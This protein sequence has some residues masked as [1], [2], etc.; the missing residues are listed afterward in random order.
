M[1]LKH[2]IGVTG[3]N[4]SSEVRAGLEF[5]KEAGVNMESKHI[6]MMG[7]LMSKRTLYDI[8]P[9]RDIA[10]NQKYLNWR[11]LKDRMELSKDEALNAV[12][13][14]SKTP[15]NIFSDMQVLFLRLYGRSNLY[16][17]NTCRAVQLNFAWPPVSE[18]E[19][20]LHNF[21]D[22]TM[23]LQLPDKATS[24]LHPSKIARKLKEYE[25][26]IDYALIDPSGG[27]GKEFSVNRA[28]S[29]YTTIRDEMPRLLVGVAGGL[30]DAN[31]YDNISRFRDA[32]GTTSF[33]VDSES[34]LRIK[35]DYID[36]L[37]LMKV[38]NYVF[39]AAQALK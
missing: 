33:S 4:T 24:G 36:D 31:A 29:L 35:T 39:G 28:A 7:F 14:A 17:S 23:I 9:K 26:V 1:S 13:Y 22:L 18:L 27:K 16:N 15:G 25:E 6:P 11:V 20:T 12:H 21:P 5:F 30:N 34:G 8:P 10:P 38:K 2:Y 37:D 19:K 3:F 32:V